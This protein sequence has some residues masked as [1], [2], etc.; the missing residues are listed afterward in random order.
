LTIKEEVS[1]FVFILFE[2]FRN[3]TAKQ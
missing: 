2:K 3:P 1:I